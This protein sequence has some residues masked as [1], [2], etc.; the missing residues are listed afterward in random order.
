MKPFPRWPLNPL[1]LFKREADH[2]RLGRWGE[3]QAERYLHKQKLKILGRRIRVGKHDELDLLAREG[4]IL[5]VIEVKT[6]SK[7]GLRP[8]KDAVDKE[9]QIRL[10]RAALTYARACT[11]RPEG[12][13]F[14]IVEVIGRPRQGKPVIRHH[15]GAFGLHHGFRY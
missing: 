3:K 1:A 2:L 5:V 7:E 15:P 10:N 6:R 8:A 14:D 4:S 12:I 9:K 11:P 13:R